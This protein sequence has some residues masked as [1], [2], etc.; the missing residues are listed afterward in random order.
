MVLHTKHQYDR[1]YSWANIQTHV[2]Q[3][4]R[5]WAHLK[6]IL[7]VFSICLWE[8]SNTMK[9]NVFPD[10]V[11]LWSEY[12]L[13]VWQVSNSN[14]QWV[15]TQTLKWYRLLPCLMLSMNKQSKVDNHCSG[16]DGPTGFLLHRSSL[17]GNSCYYLHH[18]KWTEVMFS[19][20]F[21]LFVCLF[22]CLWAGF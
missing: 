7:Q 8:I 10:S 20:L 18:Q 2:G 21:F 22:V 14:P 13:R 4:R 15:A 3:L 6:A 17:Q 1:L 5:E 9:T 11:E 16:F 19:S 12:L